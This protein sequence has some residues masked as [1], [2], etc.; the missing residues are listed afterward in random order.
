MRSLVMGTSHPGTRR[1]TTVLTPSEIADLLLDGV[2]QEGALML[3]RLLRSRLAPY[4]RWLA[5]RRRCSSSSATIAMLYLPSLN[6]DI[7]DNGVATGDTGYI[8]PHRRA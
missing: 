4:R 6:A 3:L 2:L 8:L 5:R 1:T 7:I